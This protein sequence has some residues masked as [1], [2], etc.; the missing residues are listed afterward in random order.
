MCHM[1]ASLFHPI[2]YYV[3]RR[4]YFW[5]QIKRANKTRCINSMMKNDDEDDDDVDDCDQHNQTY[6][7]KLT[8]LN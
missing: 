2:Q 6:K 8:V 5:F 7:S 3:H 1:R 4:I